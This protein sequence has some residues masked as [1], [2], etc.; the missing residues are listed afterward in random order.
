MSDKRQAAAAA[1][2]HG[3]TGIIIRSHRTKPFFSFG[4]HL[5]T[6]DL[7]KNLAFN[8]VSKRLVVPMLVKANCYLHVWC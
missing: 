5:N 4:Q 8:P 3:D 1:M 7:H 2:N 6:S